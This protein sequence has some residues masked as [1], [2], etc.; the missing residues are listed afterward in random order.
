[1]LGAMV[2]D[3]L[4]SVYE[5]RKHLPR[6]SPLMGEGCRFTDDSVFTAATAS[7]LLQ[8]RP[9]VETF[10]Q[11]GARYPGAGA[12]CTFSAWLAM[13]DPAPYG[14]ITNGALMRVSPAI[15]LASSQAQALA[16]AQAVTAVT[17]DH[18]S[19]LRAVELYAKALW[20][21]LGGATPAQTCAVLADGGVAARDVEAIHR[22]GLFRMRAD[23]TLSDVLSCL[24]VASSFE[25]LMRECIH[26]GGDVD[27]L[28]AVAGPLA[29]ALW[30]IPRP[31]VGATLERLPV[32]IRAVLA[33]EYAAL[34]ALHA[35]AW[36]RSHAQ[37]LATTTT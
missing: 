8:R 36:V 19:A 12:S 31:L 23:Q 28:C 20:A 13:A 26:C 34:D 6:D 32:D 14:G 3:V 33:A 10:R 9:V 29:E 37:V 25:G 7:A 21:A 4:G 27:T 35:G 5:R 16:Q 22:A 17:H 1:M 18:P 30:G 2:G 15:A 11:W 24:R